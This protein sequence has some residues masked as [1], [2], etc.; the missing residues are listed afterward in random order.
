MIFA[1][2]VLAIL[3]GVGL[4]IDA[5]VKA[6]P[7]YQ[8]GVKFQTNAPDGGG[9]RLISEAPRDGTV[10]ETKNAY[11]VAPT[12]GL[13]KWTDESFFEDGTAF[14]S[15]ASWMNVHKKNMGISG[16]GSWLSW[17]PYVGNV[18]DYK[19]P[20]NGVQNDPGYW[21]GAVAAKGGFRSDIY[22]VKK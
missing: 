19:D 9:W 3:I 7:A 12:Y 6:V 13:F 18:T 17:R 20:T 11:G 21:R 2:G 1:I 10:I 15:E 16:E 14:K 22:E 4:K 8:V 5:P